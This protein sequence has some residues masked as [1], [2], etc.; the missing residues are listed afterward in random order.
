MGVLLV[1]MSLGLCT[2][3]QTRKINCRR[4]LTQQPNLVFG[5]GHHWIFGIHEHHSSVDK[6]LE[7][8]GNSIRWEY[9]RL[10]MWVV[11][12]SIHMVFLYGVQMTTASNIFKRAVMAPFVFF[13]GVVALLAMRSGRTLVTEW[14]DLVKELRTKKNK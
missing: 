10:M 5:V 12:A 11:I 2:A 13:Y 7:A 8:Q 4:D 14:R 3:P 1:L 9:I 6:P